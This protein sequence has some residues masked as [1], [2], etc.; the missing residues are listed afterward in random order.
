M[1]SEEVIMHAL[2][3]S[4]AAR[5]FINRRSFLA[6]AGAVGG[7]LTFNSSI[8]RAEPTMEPSL[9]NGSTTGIAMKIKQTAGRTQLGEFA[10]TFARINDDVLFGEVWSRNDVLSLRDRSIVTV[11]ALMSQGLVDSSFRYHLESARRNGVSRLEISEILTHAAFYAGW[12]KA[13]AAFNMAKEVWKDDVQ[14]SSDSRS[15]HQSRMI[16]PIGEPNAAYEKYF[17]GRSYLAKLAEMGVGVWNVTFEPGCRNNWHIHK[18]E[19]G[20]GQILICVAG[21]G[22]YQEAG[23]PARILM[24]GDVVE[25]PSGVKHWHGAARDS[26]FSHI[27]IEVPGED[28]GSEWLEPVEDEYYL[29]L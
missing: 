24:P 12:P 1:N 26:W 28:A 16:F 19:K 10:P 25:I 9:R 17:I 2:E 14:P 5:P 7:A 27:A 21:R 29:S 18:A 3:E 23:N 20:G 13:W 15:L 22:W 11:V 8:G 4:V 6:Y